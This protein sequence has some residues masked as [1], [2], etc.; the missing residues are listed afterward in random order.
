MIS[1]HSLCMKNNQFGGLF[2]EVSNRLDKVCA[3]LM[4]SAGWRCGGRDVDG[5]LNSFGS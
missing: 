1:F 5:A 2:L 4:L 3:S